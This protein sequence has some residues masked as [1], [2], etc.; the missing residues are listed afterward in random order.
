MSELTTHLVEPED[1][2]AM[3]NVWIIWL[4]LTLSHPAL[5]QQRHVPGAVH[6]AG[7][8]P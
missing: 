8:A 3:L 1:L 7:S 5:Y 2:D 4:L 6:L